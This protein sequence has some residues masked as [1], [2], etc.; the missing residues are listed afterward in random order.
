MPGH[1]YTPAEY[2]LQMDIESFGNL[3]FELAEHQLT[4]TS[5][6]VYRFCQIENIDYLVLRNLNT[7]ALPFEEFSEKWLYDEE[8]EF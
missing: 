1:Q 6:V 2:A 5:T 8:A 7:K 4:H 3:L